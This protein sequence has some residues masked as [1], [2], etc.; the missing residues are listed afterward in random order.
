[1]DDPTAGK[2][3]GEKSRCSPRPFIAFI[4]VVL[5]IPRVVFAVYRCYFGLMRYLIIFVSLV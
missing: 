2:N 5:M 4:C 1:M 3:N